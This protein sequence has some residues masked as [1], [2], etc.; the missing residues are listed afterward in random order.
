MK[1][2]IIP[3]DTFIWNHK[4]LLD[5]LIL[6]QGLDIEILTNAEGCCA[7]TVGLYSLLDRFR[8]NSVTI[9]TANA[10]EQHPIYTIEINHGGYMYVERQVDSKYHTWNQSYYFGT[11][12]ARPLWHRIGIATHLE[13]KHKDKSTVGFVANAADVD[14]RPLFEIQQ[15]WNH[16]PATAADFLTQTDT[17]PWTHKNIGQYCPGRPNTSDYIDDTLDLYRTFLIDIVAESFTSGNCLFVTEKTIRPMVMKK[18]FIAMAAGNYLDYLHQM[19]FQTFNDFWSEEYDGF[20]GADRYVKI[21]TLIDD[22]ADKS[23]SELVE[24]YQAMQYVLDHNYH[25]LL[26][27][28][29]N[30]NIKLI[31]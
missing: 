2:T 6:N 12:Y 14:S 10:L 19:G 8:F 11:L 27:G 17:L 9:T 31:E 5:F 24:M 1:F 20:T 22:L 4:E 16:D 30:K 18:P 7:R 3:A 23:L 25:L 15:L 28:S 29:Y 26:S 13:T 21:L